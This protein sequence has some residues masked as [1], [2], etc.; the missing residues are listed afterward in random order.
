MALH[1]RVS[2]AWI[3][4]A[5]RLVKPSLREKYGVK[6]IGLFGSFAREEATPDSDIDILVEFERPIGIEFVDLADEMESLL[7][8]RV[9][10]VSRNGV[11]KPYLKLID[12][13]LV[14]V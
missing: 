11:K 4:D 8:R 3:L 5:I 12:K 6:S 9:D 10:L 7:Q 13:D 2:R 1:K 14:Y